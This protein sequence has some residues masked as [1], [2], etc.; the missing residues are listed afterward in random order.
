MTERS[1]VKISAAVRSSSLMLMRTVSWILG[2]AIVTV[3][4]VLFWIWCT[5]L[6][7]GILGNFLD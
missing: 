3:V 1:V 5:F 4:S 6:V 7:S 2:L